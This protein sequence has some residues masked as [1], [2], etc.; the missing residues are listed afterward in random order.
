LFLYDKYYEIRE[1]LS[2]GKTTSFHDEDES[3]D[4][5]MPAAF[6]ST[7]KR[8]VNL[9]ENEY[10]NTDILYWI[11]DTYWLQPMR[12][13]VSSKWDVK[14]DGRALAEAFVKWSYLMP[15]K[16]LTKFIS[17]YLK[18]RLSREIS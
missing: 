8:E 6:G 14:V 17:L 1:L 16:F 4:Y 11:F 13:Y 7:K 15:K 9:K 10:R 3:D 12:A 5:D 18:P 2:I